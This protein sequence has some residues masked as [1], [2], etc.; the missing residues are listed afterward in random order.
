MKTFQYTFEF[1]PGIKEYIMRELYFNKHKKEKEILQ[2]LCDGETCYEIADTLGYSDRTI[3][4]RRKA[5]YENTKDYMIQSFLFM[6]FVLKF[7][8]KMS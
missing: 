6:Y 3:V 8:L 1:K 7:V 5:L 4:R 2:R